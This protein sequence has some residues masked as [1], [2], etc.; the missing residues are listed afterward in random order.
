MRTGKLANGF[1]YEV[2]EKA[3]D[4][5]D[6]LDALAA[7]NEGDP[8]ATSKL[9]DLILGKEQKKKLYAMLRNDEGRV[10]VADAVNAILQIMESLGDEGKN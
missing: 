5:M 2:D 7:A 6:L 10:P 4:D 8:L 3:F 9:F 1:E